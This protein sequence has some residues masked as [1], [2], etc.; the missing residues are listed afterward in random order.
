MKHIK[1]MDGLRFIAIFLVLLE[2]FATIVEGHIS[3]GYYGVDLFFA[4]SGFLITGIL[5]KSTKSFGR[6][7]KNFIGRRTLRIFP[8]YY[9]TILILYV[10]GNEY[11]HGYLI[12]LLSYTYNYAWIYFKIPVN[13]ITHFWSLCV[14]EQFYLF[15]PFIVLGLRNHINILKGLILLLV[16]FCAAQLMFDIVPALIPY[17]EVSLIP[18]AVSLLIGGYGAILFKQ[19]KVPQFIIKSKVLEA[20]G[21]CLL[22]L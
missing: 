14:E 17:N 13:S 9:L 15:W 3:A 16:L 6:A 18:R 22:I 1:Q 12:Y 8:I 11:V 21:I 4:I 20:V 2:H 19:G 7:Y 5:L 10:A